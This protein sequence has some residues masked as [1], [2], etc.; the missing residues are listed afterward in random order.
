MA[1]LL[2]LALVA[3]SLA[4]VPACGGSDTADADPVMGAWYY[5]EGA[6]LSDTCQIDGF[7]L[8]MSTEFGLTNNG[9]GTFTVRRDGEDI[10]CDI[11]GMDFDCI[12]LDLDPV[13]AAG[14]DASFNIAVTYVGE[15][16]SNTS[17]TGERSLDAVC[18]GADCV[19]AEALLMTSFPCALVDEFSAYLE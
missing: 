2:P 15:F 9:D 6:S 12:P 5:A 7:D 11:S 8:S 13:P 18:V 14:F 1:R 3:I 19:L 16:Q 17:M 10:E 4:L